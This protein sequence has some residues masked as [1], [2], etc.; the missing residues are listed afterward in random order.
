MRGAHQLSGDRAWYSGATFMKFGRAAAIRWM[1][2][3]LKGFDP[4]C[5]AWNGTTRIERP[6][7]LAA[8]VPGSRSHGLGSEDSTLTDSSPHRQVEARRSEPLMREK[9]AEM[10]KLVDG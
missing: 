2:L 8:R 7:M 6:D 9:T 4:S 10:L 1:I 3:G 5:L